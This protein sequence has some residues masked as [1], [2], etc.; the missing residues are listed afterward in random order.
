M[1]SILSPTTLLWWRNSSMKKTYSSS[2]TT[3]QHYN[4]ITSIL[5]INYYPSNGIWTRNYYYNHN[6]KPSI[7]LQTRFLTTDS[8]NKKNETSTTEDPNPE[9]NNKTSS[10]FTDKIPIP[11]G[12][13][14]MVSQSY[15][16]VTNFFSR[17]FV[18][19]ETSWTDAAKQLFGLKSEVEPTS[20]TTTTTSSK[21]STNPTST[22][23]QSTT[24]TSTPPPPPENQPP[25]TNEQPTDTSNM[26]FGNFKTINLH[27][28]KLEELSTKLRDLD[29]QREQ[30]QNE[31]DMTKYKSLNQEIRRVK[32]EIE[33]LTK[34]INT[35]EIVKVEQRKGAW[36]HFSETLKETPL[37]KGIFGL[38]QT[39]AAKRLT[40]VA[41]DAREAWETSQHPLVYKISSTMDSIFGETEIGITIREV[42]KIDP[43]FT[44]EGLV[45]EMEESLIP[46][47]LGAF[48]RG[49]IK[50]I[51]QHCGEAATAALKAAIEERRRAGRVMDTNILNIQHTQ[52]AA[53]K[54][55]EKMGP[56]LVIQF[57]A[58]Q[59]DVLYDLNGKV[60]EGSDDKVAAVFYA[61]ALTRDRDDITG[62]LKWTVK[63]F[64]IV[65]NLP[66]T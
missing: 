1:K 59:I 11:D 21:P 13:K 5:T 65:G 53:A 14:K 7:I 36:E 12:A 15:E 31:G 44:L 33:D 66:W 37:L 40:N 60:A 52:V 6:N 63:E 28:V 64:A 34:K 39:N 30:A 62:Q 45:T 17:F 35:T 43:K 50:T 24:T 29:T 56:L 10:S 57:M 54:V 58:Q 27:E 20:T 41:E 16:T 49:D 18:K 42:R 25:P 19:D 48:L 26:E 4:P 8:P 9:N 47:V 51:Q 3:L 23:Q 55:V 46:T 32:R 61:F 2:Q 38:G 22:S